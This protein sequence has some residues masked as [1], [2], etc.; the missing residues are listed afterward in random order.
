MRIAMGSHTSPA[1]STVSGLL[2]VAIGLD[3]FP[4][5]IFRGAITAI[6]VGMVAFH[7]LLEPRLDVRTGRAILQP[8]RVKRLA[9]GVAHGAPLGLGARLCRTGARTSELP[10]DVEPILETE[11]L[12]KR[13][14]G[15]SLG[16]ALSA[17]HPDPPIRKM[18][19][20]RILMKPRNRDVARPVTKVIGL[21]QFV[22][23]V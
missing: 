1:K 4:Q 16:T 10:Q 3:V 19:G 20:E 21:I 15:L 14:T 22:N 6:G 17:D 7:Q 9:L 8:E 13:S 23:V 2:E 18:S 12:V 11:T 5:F